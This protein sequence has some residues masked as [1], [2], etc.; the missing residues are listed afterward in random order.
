MSRTKQKARK[1]T[2]GQR[3]KRTEPGDESER[4]AAK[5]VKISD[6]ERREVKKKTAASPDDNGTA[7]SPSEKQAVRKTA[8]M[9]PTSSSKLDSFDESVAARDPAL[10]SDLIVQRIQKHFTNLTSLE[11]SDLGLPSSVFRDTTGFKDP[12][13]ADQLPNFLISQTSSPDCLKTCE[14][15]ASPHT[16]VLAAAGMRV[17]DLYRALVVFN[18]K[19]VK[20]GKLIT[21]HMK[22]GEM[23]KYLQATKVGII[24]TTPKRMGDLIEAKAVDLS[25]LRRIVI[26]GSYQNEKKQCLLDMKDTFVQTLELLNMATLTR[27]Q[28]DDAVQAVLAL[29]TEAAK[30][31]SKVPS[32]AVLV[33]P[34]KRTILLSHLSIS[35]VRHAE[36]ELARLAVDHFSTS[37]LSRCTLV[38]TWEPCAM[39]AGTIYWSGIGTV[40]Y[41][42]SQAKLKELL[43]LAGLSISCR[44]VFRAG[45]RQVEVIGPV[46]EWQDQVVDESANWWR[47]LQQQQQGA[48][49]KTRSSQGATKTSADRA[50]DVTIWTGEDSVLS[51]IGEDGEYKAELNIDWMR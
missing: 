1:G 19:E 47:E 4:P 20:V 24:I 18:T 49:A 38:S 14:G 7:A 10:L 39:C 15:T 12:H 23:T 40:V 5:R 36:S 3:Q 44:T 8:D 26:D 42:A 17:A 29:Q 9:P 16:A 43:L 11:Q 45:L 22:L 33:G 37:Y 32:A 46:P 25:S 21:K 34:D 35:H 6:T 48:A 28:V 2:G 31:H 50:K 30:M 13:V 27:E 41:V 51:S